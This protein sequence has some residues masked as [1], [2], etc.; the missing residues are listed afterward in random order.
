MAQ[1][2]NFNQ[3]EYKNIFEPFVN[4]A[5]KGSYLTFTQCRK[6]IVW[7]ITHANYIPSYN[8]LTRKVRSFVSK[9]LGVKVTVSQQG[10]GI[11]ILEDREASPYHQNRF[12]I[13]MNGMANSY[14]NLKNIEQCNLNHLEKLDHRKNLRNQNQILG[15]TFGMAIKKKLLSKEDAKIKL[16]G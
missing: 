2:I 9:R 10:K 7:D 1:S 16:G 15:V 3:V 14:N 4:T 13:N 6:I 12:E 8:S 11:R 5:I